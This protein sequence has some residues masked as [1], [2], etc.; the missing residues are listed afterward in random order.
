MIITTQITATTN[1][2][3]TQ[4]VKQF[5]VRTKCQPKVGILSRLLL[6]L[7]FCPSQFLVGILSGPYQ[8]VLAFCQN[9]EKCS[10]DDIREAAKNV[11]ADF[12]R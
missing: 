11:L 12:V 4:Q 1:G 9:H 3:T 8:H 6:W 5:G 7:A 10:E 2:V